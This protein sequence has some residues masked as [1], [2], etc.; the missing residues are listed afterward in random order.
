MLKDQEF[1][2][3]YRTGTNDIVNEFYKKAFN[4]SI[5]YWRAV[6]YFRSSS[7]EAF[8][9]TLQ[10]FLQNDGTIKLITS[11]ELTEADS[12]AIEKGMSK[13]EV[14]EKRI[15]AIIDT[16]F[17]ENVGNGVSRLA[18]LLEIGRLEIKIALRKTDHGYFLYH[19]KVGV[20]FDAERNYVAFSGSQNESENAFENNFESID[21][22]TSWNDKSR[23]EKKKKHF[24]S[25]WNSTNE[26]VA[27]FE[28]SDAS[29]KS[30]YIL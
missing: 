24:E 23:A 22:F 3:E 21:V 28:F 1:L 7:L 13:Q 12:D 25:L 8:G 16:E 14:C 2:E 15:N 18:Y 4:E 30:L 29:K 6:G 19:E 9:S 5:E 26:H 10:N 27:I 11:V 20:F 17:N